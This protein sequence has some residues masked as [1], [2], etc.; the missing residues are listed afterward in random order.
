M[1]IFG[2]IILVFVIL[3]L[4]IAVV[5]QDRD[6]GRVMREFNEQQEE[7]CQMKVRVKSLQYE[8]L[9]LTKTQELMLNRM[10]NKSIIPKDV[11]KPSLVADDRIFSG[12]GL[13]GL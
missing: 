1:K 6:T 11:P 2:T 13:E 12:D 5:A 10:L 3:F 9:L 8:I 7:I 4:L